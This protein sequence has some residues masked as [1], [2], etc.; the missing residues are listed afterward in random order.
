[1]DKHSEKM[2]NCR[3]NHSI[4]LLLSMESP[5]YSSPKLNPNLFDYVI[6][7]YPNMGMAWTYDTFELINPGTNRSE[8]YSELD[9]SKAVNK[10]TKPL[11]I[12]VSHCDTNSKREKYINILSKYIRITNYGKCSGINCDDICAEKAFEEHYFYL[13]FENSVCDHYITE[14]FWNLKK[15]IV[16]IVLSRKSIEN[17]APSNT[18]I[19]I[20]DFNNVAEF[21]GYLQF[22]MDNKDEYSK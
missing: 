3:K 1:M 22:L 7:Y 14:K 9:V 5:I 13:A 18:Y 8:I 15:L 4:Q 10:K 2:V 19:A 6:S 11:L 12:L 20:D 17:V 21:A 16:P